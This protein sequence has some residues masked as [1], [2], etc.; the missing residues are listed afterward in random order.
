MR[1]S[2][3]L[4]LLSGKTGLHAMPEAPASDAKPTIVIVHGAWGGSW[5]FRQLDRLLRAKGF[6]VYRPSLTGLGERVHLSSPDVGLSTHVEDVVNAIIFEEL[7]D[8]VLVGHSYG[9]MVISGVADRMPDRIRRLVYLDAFV[10]ED[11]ESVVDIIGSRAQW[12]RDMMKGD[13]LVPPWIDGRPW[14]YDVPQSVKTFTEPLALSGAVKALPATYI[15]MLEAGKTA[16]AADFAPFVERARQRGWHVTTM[17]GDH[18]PQNSAPQAL[19]DLLS[20]EA[21]RSP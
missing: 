4:S 17:T 16:E 15:L 5:A 11:G 6:D 7:H 8:V 2:H 3:L 14:P 13:F 9:G 10:P 21:M 12:A 19:A 1:I 18:N 20:A